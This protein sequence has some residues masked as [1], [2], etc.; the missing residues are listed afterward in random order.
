[1]PILRRA[2]HIVRLSEQSHGAG[3]KQ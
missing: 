3:G 2:Q 1:M